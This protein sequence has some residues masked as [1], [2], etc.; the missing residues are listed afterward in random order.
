[1]DDVKKLIAQFSCFQDCSS[2]S[3]DRNG[4]TFEVYILIYVEHSHFRYTNITV[5]SFCHHEFVNSR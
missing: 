1:M 3:L 5:C 4:E 2:D